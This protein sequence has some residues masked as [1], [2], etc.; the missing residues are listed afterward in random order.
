M[1]QDRRGM[2]AASSPFRQNGDSRLAAT[3]RS[4]F[5]RQIDGLGW[6]RATLCISVRDPRDYAR[7]P[8]AG[9]PAG[10]DI[11]PGERR[12][13]SEANAEAAWRRE[14][15]A[16]MHGYGTIGLS[17]SHVWSAI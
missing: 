4:G 9:W 1:L 6:L 17:S 16:L 13:D 10:P 15:T 14:R 5:R 8:R 7:V 3:D 11:P 2:N 12:W